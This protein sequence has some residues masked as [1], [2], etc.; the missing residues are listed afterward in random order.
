MQQQS[1]DAEF[2]QQTGG[3]ILKEHLKKKRQK[4]EKNKG[5]FCTEKLVI[6]KNHPKEC[7]SEYT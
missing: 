4:Q 3:R 7:Y 5:N 2:V 1:G 6:V